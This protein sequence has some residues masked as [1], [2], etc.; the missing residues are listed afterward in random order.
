M[1]LKLLFFIALLSITATQAQILTFDFASLAG[2]EVTAN[3]NFNNPNLTGSTISRGAGLTASGNLDRF[4]ATSW[5]LT[6]IANAVTGNDYMEFTVSPNLGFNFDIT[7]VTVN[8]QRSGTGPRGIA[9][10]SS[11]DGYSS[12]LGGEQAIADLTSTQSFTFVFS[13]TNNNTSVT[14]RVYMWAEDTSGSGGPGDFTGNDII[15]NGVVY[16]AVATPTITTTPASLSGFIYALGS[17]PSAEQSFSISGTSLTNNITITAPTHYEISLTTGGV[18]SSSLTLTPV[19]GVVPLTPVYVRLRA[20]LAVNTYNGETITA[21]S[22][23]ATNQNVVCNGSVTNP[24]TVFTPGDF[25]VI[26]LN[27]NITC[28]PPGPNGVYS[29][30]DDEISFI[31][32]KDILNGD[33]FYI[34]DNGF[35]R[36]TANEW[37]DTEGL[38]FFTRTGGTIPAGTVI[39]FR[40]L[41]GSPFVEFNSPDGAWLFNK[42]AGF[43]GNLAMNAGG[44]QLF[45]TQGGTW[46]NPAGTHDATYSGGEYV[47]GFNTNTGWNSFANSTQQS[48]LPINLNCFSLL[49]GSATDFL[50]Y[51]GATTPASKLDWIARL[52]NPANWTNRMSCAGYLRTHVGQTYTVLTGGTYVD[53]IWTGSKSTDWFDCSNWQTLEVPNQTV[54][55]NINNAFATRDAVIS[56]TSPLAATYSN[57]AEANNL[58]ITDRSLI[59]E[60]NANNV[61][62]LNGNL[63]LGGTGILD[64][65][66]NNPATADGTLRLR[67]NWTNNRTETEFREGNS[68]VH[69]IGTTNQIINNVAPIG[70]EVFYNVVLENNFTTSISNDLIATGNLTV[71]TGRTV[72]VSSN[73]YI[74]VNNNLTVNGNFNVRDD[75]SL[76]QVNDS[77][78][79]VGAIAYERITTGN[80]ND[81]VYWSSPV[82]GVNTPSGFVYTWDADLPNTNGGEGNWVGAAGSPM[83]AGVGYIMRNIF[84]RTFMGQP[85]NG[86]IQPAITR[87][88]YQGGDYAGTNGVTITRFSDNWNLVGNP[89]PSAI[90]VLDFLA[91]NANIEGA[92]R[93]WTHNTALSAAIPNP[94]YGSF[95]ANYTPNDYI[96]YNALGTVSGPAGFNGYIAGGQSFMVNMIDGAAT[97]Q[98]LIF[99]NS[100]R[101]RVYNNSQFYRAAHP[102]VTLATLEKHRFWLDLIDQNKVSERVLVGYVENA[103]VGKDRMFDAVTGVAPSFLK[104]Y[105]LL[106]NDKMTIEGRPLPFDTNDKVMI[107]VNVPHA[108][109]Y[110][111]ALAAVDGIFATKQPIYIEDR[112]LG[113]VRDLTETPYA[114]TADKSGEINNR[115][116]IRYTDETLSTGDELLVNAPIIFNNDSG[117]NFNF[118]GIEVEKLIIHDVLGRQLYQND[119]I[120][121]QEIRITTIEKN[122]Q[123][124]VI[125]LLDS[126]T[127]KTITI[128]HMY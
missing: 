96:T 62:V 18:F 97:T 114:F 80:T 52:N 86:L 93:I 68:T 60:A 17:G 47:Y 112:L 11:V 21:A 53:G 89:Y 78:V 41:N 70:T 111:I 126:K 12:N 66:D 121:S 61:L 30:G 67:G 74:Q 55:V 82:N 57:L 107:G 100:L 50:E 72:T 106:E 58:D 15:V 51:T 104:I 8:L 29:A 4:N 91:L 22:S 116:V 92:V 73:D 84:S 79:N 46:T 101:S 7:S 76:I 25:A 9:L 83:L 16:P 45:F 14:Y 32:F 23:G 56:I 88:T 5:A 103:T 120:K 33:S 125:S 28:Y 49:P 128:K 90:N 31:T 54:D 105:T 75:G 115:F 39:T 44:D 43:G 117:I 127:G 87:G 27:S 77:G 19:A 37:G 71:G 10:R 102:S 85:R 95:A 94:F 98:N 3:S 65:D 42:V 63:T 6:S 81:Y 123:L 113:I 118:N 20:G 2:N 69:F 108:G 59:I 124:L 109:N 38:Y 99:N 26:A 40:F 64:M 110:S 1:K 24:S 34:T 119:H 48:G 35:Q 36:A 122:Q 13:Q